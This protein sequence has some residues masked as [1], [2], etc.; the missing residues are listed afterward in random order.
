MAAAR[1]HRQ[2]FKAQEDLHL[3]LSQ[4]DPQ[5]FVAMDVGRAVEDGI[6]LHVAVRMQGRLFPFGHFKRL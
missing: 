5:A 1:M 2:A 4:L 6:D 3:R